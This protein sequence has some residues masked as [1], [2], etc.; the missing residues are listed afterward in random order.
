M[1]EKVLT[2]QEDRES[3]IKEPLYAHLRCLLERLV[4]QL[5]PGEP[6]V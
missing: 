3:F 6:A 4:H 5:Y 2:G 1:C